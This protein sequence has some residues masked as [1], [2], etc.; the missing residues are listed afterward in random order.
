[1]TSI[2]RLADLIE[3][4]EQSGNE[5]QLAATRAYRAQYGVALQGVKG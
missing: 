5:S 4:L 3:Y 2:L 1:V